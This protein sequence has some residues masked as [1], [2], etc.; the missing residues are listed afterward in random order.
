MILHYVAYNQASDFLILVSAS[1][2]GDGSS[3][4]GP[5]LTELCC[6]DS[7]TRP[8][9]Q[10][11]GGIPSMLKHGAT[12]AEGVQDAIIRNLEACEALTTITRT[13]L[14]PNGPLS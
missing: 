7:A 6:S 2:Q 11:A 12:H 3:S 1:R 8:D 9:M 4:R 5:A 14:G 13:S 10:Q